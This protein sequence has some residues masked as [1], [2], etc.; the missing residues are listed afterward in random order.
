MRNIVTSLLVLL[1]GSA[2]W[3]AGGFQ[4]L[5]NGKDLSDWIVDTPAVWTIQDGVLIG[6]SEGLNYHEYLRTKEHY[7]NFIL[8]LKMRIVGGNGNSGIQFRSWAVPNSHNVAGYQAD[9]GVGRR[10][11]GI[12]WGALYCEARHKML[13]FPGPEFRKTVDL[14]GWHEYVI[15]ARGNRIRL[16]LDGVTTVEYQEQDPAV[17]RSGFI[18]LQVHGS[19]EPLEV[20]F[21]DLSIQVLD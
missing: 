17:A 15:T 19:R 18:A 20:H 11:P 4:S 13:G 6:K 16:E 2:L 21:K 5:W 7:S 1:T 3:A 8:K 10:E 14:D 12:Y 9:A